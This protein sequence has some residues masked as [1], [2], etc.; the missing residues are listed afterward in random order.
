MEQFRA[1]AFSVE[2]SEGGLKELVRRWFIDT[3]A[4]HIL[5]DG[6]FPDW[7]QGFATRKCI[8][9]AVTIRDTDDL[10]KDKSLGC[11]LLRLSDKTIGYIL[12]Y[13]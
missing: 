13:K 6:H 12:S 1:T 8:C 9:L 11:F 5:Q 4:S 2:A 7:F 3:Q 10:L